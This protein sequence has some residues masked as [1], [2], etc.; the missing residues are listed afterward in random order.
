MEGLRLGKSEAG[1][2]W[3]DARLTSPYRLYQYFLNTEDSVVGTYL[4]FFTFLD[5]EQLLELDEATARQPQQR[6]AQRVLAAEVTRLVHG[7]AE[8]RRAEAAT[9]AL[10]GGDV[11]GLDPA[12][13]E[14]IADDAPSSVLPLAVLEGEGLDVAEA[15]ALCGLAPSRSA[16][17]TAVTQG[18]AYVNN[19]RVPPEGAR[20]TGADLLAGRYVL[21]RRGRR[22]VHLLRFE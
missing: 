10:H 19:E 14:L 9:A 5:H 18:G 8:L 6:R 16:A 1:A 22:D 4:R 12:T 20:L 3:L 21:L 7:E 2:L 17:R 15:L 11:R 13:L